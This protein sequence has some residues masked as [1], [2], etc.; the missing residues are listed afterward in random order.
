[1]RRNLWRAIGLALLAVFSANLNAQSS[2][3]VPSDSK[4]VL[5]VDLQALK[6]SKVGSALLEMAKKATRSN[7]KDAW[8]ERRTRTQLI[9]EIPQACPVGLFCF[10]AKQGE[11]P[12]VFCKHRKVEKPPRGTML[13]VIQGARLRS[14]RCSD[15]R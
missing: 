6:S 9:S 5:Q 4:F 10:Q 3:S 1:M 7:R 11:Q 12:H 13:R 14:F 8:E 2:I 15:L